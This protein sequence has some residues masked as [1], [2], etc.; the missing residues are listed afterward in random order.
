V[1][2]GGRRGMAV[3][4]EG[5]RTAA[6]NAD[7]AAGSRSRPQVE[8]AS[9]R[10][11]TLGPG[12]HGPVIPHGGQWAMIMN[13]LVQHF[14]RAPHPFFSRVP[15]LQECLLCYSSPFLT[16]AH[17]QAMGWLLILAGCAPSISERSMLSKAPGSAAPGTGPPGP[18]PDT[19]AAAAALEP[20]GPQVAAAAAAAAAAAWGVGATGLELWL[21]LWS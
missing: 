12:P 18:P 5:W 15:P 20:S 21:F 14:L 6:A 10:L 7:A 8:A 2:V 19:A 11:V 4:V 13:L 3:R 1:R 17:G 9:R 16:P